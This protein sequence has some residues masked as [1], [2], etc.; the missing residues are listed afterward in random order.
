[1]NSIGVDAAARGSS[2]ARGM[3]FRDRAPFGRDRGGGDR[4]CVACL[5]SRVRGLGRDDRRE[6]AAGL[7]RDGAVVCVLNV[8]HGNT[9]EV[10]RL[11][12]AAI[13]DYRRLEREL[14]GALAVEWNGAL[15]WSEEPAES[16]RAVAEPTAW[17]HDV[18]LVESG[19]IRR[20]EPR[21][22]APPPVAV[23]APGD[24]ALDPIAATSALVSAA[25]EVGARL[26]KGSEVKALATTDGRVSGVVLP[27]GAI[28]A[29]IVVLAAG[30]G[31]RALCADIGI[32]LPVESSPATLL[33]FSGPEGLIGGVVSGPDLEIRQDTPGVCSS[34][35]TT[36]KVKRW[37]AR[38][39]T[40]S[41][42]SAAGSAASTR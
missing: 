23:H 28:D 9:P 33:R 14:S 32:E 13:E 31:S 34:V 5:S 1:M 20:L 3:S 18:R 21:L 22:V 37:T 12:S 11:R 15:A 35:T 4:R 7:G 25:M 29:D 16:E 6:I 39:R 38:P 17:G 41:P 26:V 8:S 19:E 27:S 2:P 24:G 10:A 40:R 42:W 30:T 36:S